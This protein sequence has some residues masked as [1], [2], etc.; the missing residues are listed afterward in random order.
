MINATE[1][2]SHLYLKFKR[3]LGPG[4]LRVLKIWSKVTRHEHWNCLRT[5]ICQNQADGCGQGH[6]KHVLKVNMPVVK[7]EVLCENSRKDCLKVGLNYLRL[8][9]FEIFLVSLNDINSQDMKS[10]KLV[11]AISMF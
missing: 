6:S 9:P 4:I 3:L 2:S 5:G 11:Y 8:V 1:N 10:W 7:P